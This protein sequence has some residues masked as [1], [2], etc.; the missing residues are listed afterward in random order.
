[1]TT[2]PTDHRTLNPDSHNAS[3]DRGAHAQYANALAHLSPAVRVG[4]QQARQAAS[5]AVPA[6][7]PRHLVWV[8]AG[9][10]AALC[11]IVGLQLQRTPSGHQ[12]SAPL[13]TISANP[14]TDQPAPAIDDDDEVARMLAALDENPDFY[15]WLAANDSALPPPSER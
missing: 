5:Q 13:A 15:L 3:F 1:M 14:A 7:S 12:P 8:W 6:R 2:R 11:L 4:L 10:A 9:T